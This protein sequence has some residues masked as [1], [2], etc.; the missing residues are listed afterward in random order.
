MNNA[1]FTQ[2]DA[3]PVPPDA[4]SDPFEPTNAG[5]A[6]TTEDVGGD[7]VTMDPSAETEIWVG[8]THWKH[9]AGW[10][11]M[12]IMANVVL[13][14]LLVWAAHHIKWL[15]FKRGFAIVAVVFVISGLE[16]AVR[17]VFLKIINHR[18]RLTSQRLFIERG[19]L[20]QTVDQTEL[21][22][23]DDVRINKSFLDRVFGLGSVAIVSTDATDRKVVVEGIPE[24]ESVAEAIRTHMRT[25]RRKSVFIEHL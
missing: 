3:Q 7:G 8:R 1:D 14:V 6:N 10:L 5:T 11:A 13:T 18:Y 25:M 21:I 9:Y 24:A 22:R 15:T 23:V 19:I 12:W 4:T 17:R 2:P 20:S 16:V